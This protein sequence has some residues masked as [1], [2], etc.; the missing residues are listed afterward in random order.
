MNESAPWF[1]IRPSSGSTEYPG[2]VEIWRSSVRATH[3]FLDEKDFE[4]IE[5][6]LIPVYFPAVAMLVADTDD[7]PVG[8]AGVAEGCLEMLFV[9]D[10]ARGRGVGTALLHEAVARYGVTEVDVNEQNTGALGF[11]LSQGFVQ[12][13]RSE[14]DGDGRPY[15]LLHLRRAVTR[16]SNP[17]HGPVARD[18]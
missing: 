15:P 16:G 18:R 7:G 5:A 11:Y 8:F 1:F 3:D 6:S 9:S 17:D 13:G 2:L 12:V 10:S 4:R 14:L